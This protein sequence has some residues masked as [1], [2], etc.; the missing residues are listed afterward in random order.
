MRE[1][2][3]SLESEVSSPRLVVP[4][5]SIGSRQSP[6]ATFRLDPRHTSYGLLTTDY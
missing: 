5:K 4:V 6:S 2:V 3:G 1:E